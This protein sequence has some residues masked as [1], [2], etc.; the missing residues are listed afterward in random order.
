VENFLRTFNPL[1]AADIALQGAPVITPGG[2]AVAADCAPAATA[3][4]GEGNNALLSGSSTLAPNEN[5]TIA[6]TVRVSNLTAITYENTAYGSTS[7]N[8]SNPGLTVPATGAVGAPAG[9][10]AQDESDA[11]TSPTGNNG[12]GGS[13]DPTPLPLGT[14]TGVVSKTPT[15]TAHKTAAKLV[16]AYQWMWL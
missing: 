11:G 6:L 14:L 8:P 10:L 1:G 15:A 7:L 4:S 16:W 13:N 9:T 3:F 2:G 5:C 12:S